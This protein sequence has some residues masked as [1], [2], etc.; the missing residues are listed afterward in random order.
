VH[1]LQTK[2]QQDIEE[3]REQIADLTR[4]L[5]DANA[6]ALKFMNENAELK[7]RLQALELKLNEIEKS[8]QE[9]IT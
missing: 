7:Q 9:L 5:T 8:L 3:L 1:E 6:L 4:K 2:T